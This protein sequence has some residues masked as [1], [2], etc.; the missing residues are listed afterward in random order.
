MR[1]EAAEDALAAA[2]ADE[3][4]ASARAA[5]A[6]AALTA[7]K[8]TA[9]S[10]VQEAV[11]LKSKLESAT[12]HSRALEAER[13]AAEERLAAAQEREATSQAQGEVKEQAAK[14]KA[15]EAEQKLRLLSQEH[16]ELKQEVERL[17]EHIEGLEADQ[18]QMQAHHAEQLAAAEAKVAAARAAAAEKGGDALSQAGENGVAAGV[19]GDGGALSREDSASEA[20]A[21]LKL[22]NGKRRP[23]AFGAG[24]ANGAASTSAD[25]DTGSPWRSSRSSHSSG[26]FLIGAAAG[27][28]GETGQQVSRMLAK[29]QAEANAAIREKEQTSEQL[30]QALRRAADAEAA[31]AEGRTWKEQADQVQHKVQGW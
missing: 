27:V 11:A 7:A 25:A 29:L 14:E 23:S 9:S 18:E 20:L 30:Y 13:K 10:A 28:T 3:R 15:W 21:A 17:R 6:E 8:D 31:A 2:Q 26:T 22:G 24:E 19:G 12:R 5:A 4:T 16:E 1:L